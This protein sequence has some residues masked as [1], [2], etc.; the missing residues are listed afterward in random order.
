MFYYYE[1]KESQK[2]FTEELYDVIKEKEELVIVCVG[3]DRSTG[4]CLG[5]LVG[6]RLKQSLLYNTTVYGTLEHPV[7]ALN[8][9]EVLCQIKKH[10][11]RA[12]VL[13]VDAVLWKVENIGKV[14]IKK[15]PLRPGAGVHKNLPV[16]GDAMIGGVVNV[17]GYM[18][19]TV[20]Q[21]TRLFTV[22]Q[23]ADLI[24]NSI[25][26]AI[27]QSTPLGKIPLFD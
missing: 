8:L 25:L 18:E 1:D 17:G 7:H 22:V 15:E 5:P 10:H 16:I 9:E 24:S 4:D 2:R 21:N 26:H 19:M 13:A 12:F 20:L 3:T 14:Y 23:L 27:E 11:V 6:E